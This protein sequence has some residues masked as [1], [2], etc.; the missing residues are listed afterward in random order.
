MK[1]KYLYTAILTLV[2][3]CCGFAQISNAVIPGF[4]S[5]K[6]QYFE[7]AR[8]IEDGA[9]EIKAK[10]TFTDMDT[11][12]KSAI[13]ELSLK[14]WD[15]EMIFIRSDYS[16][17]NIEGYKTE[18]WTKNK[19]TGLISLVG[20][21]DLNSTDVSKFLPKQLETTRKHP[22]FFYIGGQAN[23]NDDYFSMS[24]NARIGSFL[25]KDR[26][27]IALS[28][29]YSGDNVTTMAEL[30]LMSRLFC[31]IRK[32]N[33]S[34]YIG[35]GFSWG[36]IEDGGGYTRTMLLLG[37]SWYVGHGSLDFGLQIS[38]D[39]NVTIGYTFLF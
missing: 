29:S 39:F 24:W 18:L 7:D 19:H 16:E 10:K 21:W 9:L 17:H 27:D 23:F 20:N 34:P 11:S 14:K 26:W 28:G 4:L 32:Y 13:L 2:C 12:K 30:G 38:K 35:A 31:P 15:G 3:C 37:S 8:L 5:E 33:L 6:A 1:M 22:W 36:H 25:Y